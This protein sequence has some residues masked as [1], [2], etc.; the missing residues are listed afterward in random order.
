MMQAPHIAII[1][2]NTLAMMGMKS[3]LHQVMPTIE[4]DCFGS[5]GELSANGP[6]HFFHYFVS[7]EIMLRHRAF[8]AANR[9]KTIVLTLSTE[10]HAQVSEFHNLC[11]NVPEQHLVKALLTL[12]Q[13]A[14]AHGKNIPPQHVRQ[15]IP[16]PTVLLTKREVDVMVLIVQ[17]FIN[18]EI[19]DR[20]NIGLTTVVTHRKNVMEKLGIKS[21]SALTIYAVTHGY[22]DINS[23]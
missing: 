6:E 17:G 16:S 9:Q 15:A 23:I 12:V 7:M 3:I 14:H 22:V 18:K 5:F 4:I 10:A 8:F 2:T 19:A 21:V 13:H 1:D 20:L 11:V